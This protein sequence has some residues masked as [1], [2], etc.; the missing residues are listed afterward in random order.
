MKLTRLLITTTVS[1]LAIAPAF[2]AEADGGED[3]GSSRSEIIVT[4]AKSRESALNESA[5]ATGL[6]LSLRETPQ[7]VTVVDRERI[8]DFALTNVND[9]L[10]QAVG[11]TVQ[12]NETDR[13]DFTAR[14]FA[15]TNL[16][17][18]GIGLPLLGRLKMTILDLELRPGATPILVGQAP[19]D[20]RPLALPLPRRGGSG[21]GCW[22][23]PPR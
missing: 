8:D 15:V 19:Q 5:S 18:D 7:S 22:S 12:R 17:V 13:T 2:A 23:S 10:E 4:A 14:G 9:L 1:A 21:A 11:I 3:R 16:Q 20:T 6:D